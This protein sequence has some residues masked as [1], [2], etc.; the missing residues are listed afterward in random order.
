M[1][2][3]FTT[4]PELRGSFGA[5]A[6]THWIG[7][8]VGM[9]ILERGGN[10]FDAAVATGFTLQIVEPHLNG[11]GGDVPIILHAADADRPQVICGQGTAPAKADIATYKSLGCDLIPGT[12]F[13]AAVV[14]GAFDAWMLLLR[15]YGTMTLR[16]VLQPAVSYANNGFPLMM[17]V[18][19]AIHA[20]ADFMKE[21]WPTSA[22]VWLPGGKAP[23]P[24]EMFKTPAI[25]AMYE[26]ILSEA[27]AVGGDREAQIEAAR[28]AF[29]QGFVAEAIDTFCAATEAMDA[30]GNRNKGLLTG[31]DMA[32]WQATLEDTASVDY[33]DV[34]VHKTGPWGQGPV[35]LQC[36]SVLK[37]VDLSSLDPAGDQFIHLVAETMKLAFADRDA[38][39]GDPDFIDVPLESLLS[40]DYGAERL[41]Q[42]SDKANADLRPGPVHMDV[43]TR[44]KALLELANC[45]PPKIDIGAGEPTFLNLSP[46]EGDTVHLDVTDQWGNMVTATPSAGWLQSSPAIPGLGFNLSTRSQMFWLDERL[47]SSLEPGK[48]PRT[49]LTPTLVTRDGKPYMA[50]GSP[51]GDQQDQWSLIFFLRQLH[52]K[53]NLQAAIDAPLFNTRHMVSSFYPRPFEPLALAIEGRVPVEVRDA[54]AARG[55]A[56]DVT[57]DWALGRLCAVSRGARGTIRAAATP[58][59]MQAYAAGR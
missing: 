1:E 11:P 10:A 13:L 50:F 14:P 47:P 23:M 16:E 25:G 37:G 39:Y 17:R 8:A 29:Y 35:M 6:S 48:R 18:A 20:V 54:L 32:Q 5:V 57:D 27:E 28:A 12:G 51:G 38:H 33:H 30:T 59:L 43:E 3:Q 26:R 42:I 34:E 36:L 44:T 46:P 22:E 53:L 4:R 19:G 31:D 9:G 45:Q 7:T 58:R 56:L 41:T 55:H 52:H 24:N 49:T 2:Q 21:E 15:D 40:D